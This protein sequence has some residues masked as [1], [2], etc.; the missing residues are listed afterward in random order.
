MTTT[1]PLPMAQVGALG[2]L[3]V[4]HFALGVAVGTLLDEKIVGKVSKRERVQSWWC[5]TK[6]A[7]QVLLLAIVRHY[8]G[9]LLVRYP[10]GQR[11]V[12]LREG[13]WAL[14][15]GLISSQRHLMERL[16]FLVERWA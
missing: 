6:A 9:A 8:L 14:A 7:L 12:V 11:D 15:V 3:S 2:A 13:G 5:V 1:S 16:A 4:G 10:L